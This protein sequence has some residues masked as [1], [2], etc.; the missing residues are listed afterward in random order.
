MAYQWIAVPLLAFLLTAC[1]SGGSRDDS[2]D[3]P[4]RHAAEVNTK[5]GQAYMARGQ[6]E[7]ALDKLK[8]AVREDNSY[9]PAHTVLAVLYE[10]I[11]ETDLAE[12]HYH[13]A[14]EVDP[15]DGDVNNNYGA[16]LCRT[17]KS[18]QA[19]PYFRKALED[20]FYST[21]A[22]AMANAGSCALER[23]ET[24]MAETYL[25]QS[26]GFDAE[27]P[28]ALLTMAGLK[29]QTADY[30]SA[31]GF[32]QRYESVGPMTPESLMTGYQIETRMNN[33]TDARQY[34]NRLLDLFPD[35][36][37]AGEIRDSRRQ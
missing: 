17:D 7:I 31:R 18:A 37:Q 25:R 2:D 23:G 29:Y 22:V 28:D 14:V 32:L 33:P 24:E 11:G 5:L 30:F 10:R 4:G 16:F 27:F 8:K 13:E 19:D 3:D 12:K 26:L 1:A 15:N 36:A 35:S 20:P 9:A 34:G 6:Y 21:P